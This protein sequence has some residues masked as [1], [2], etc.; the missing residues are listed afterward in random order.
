V[1]C[2][3]NNEGIFCL[4]YAET[5]LGL[6]NKELWMAQYVRAAVK[7]ARPHRD[8]STHQRQSSTWD[9]CTYTFV[10][11]DE[12]RIRHLVTNP[13]IRTP[14]NHITLER[15]RCKMNGRP[16]SPLVPYR[17]GRTEWYG[18]VPYRT[19]P[20][21]ANGNLPSESGFCVHFSIQRSE[22]KDNCPARS[23]FRVC[24]GSPRKLRPFL[25]WLTQPLPRGSQRR[26]YCTQRWSTRSNRYNE[27][28]CHGGGKKSPTRRKCFKR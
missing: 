22:L 17:T 8:P 13:D 2:S 24:R 27:S 11:S 25:S 26:H 6:Q 1:W 18:M 19:I 20:K 4:V 16:H 10:S 15:A 7:F 3:S 5:T 28:I 14:V 21:A 23:F 9:L 12:Y